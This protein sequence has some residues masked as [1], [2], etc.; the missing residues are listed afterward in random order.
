MNNVYALRLLWKLCPQL[1]VHGAIVRVLGYFE[2][3]FYSAFFMR[4]VINA[5][6]TEAE[7]ASILTFLGVTIC[8]FA[9]MSLYNNYVEGRVLPV[10]MATVYKKL[11]LELFEKAGKMYVILIPCVVTYISN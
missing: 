2:W 8:V 11:N 7:L 6:E 4:Y 1:V 3:L 5:L 9:G 10:S